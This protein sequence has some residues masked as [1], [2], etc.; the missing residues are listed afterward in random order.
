MTF[1]KIRE[2]NY[3]EMKMNVLVFEHIKTGAIH[4]HTEY[5]TVQNSFNVTFK[6]LPENNN[7]LPHILEHSVLNGSEKFPMHGVFFAMQ[8]RNFETFSNAMTG[9]DMTQ[10]PFS[11]I[12]ENGYFNLLSVYLDAVFFPKLEKEVFLQEGWRY[13]FENPQDIN[14]SLK[15]SGVVYNE[16]K[17]AYENASRVAYVEMLRQ[18][19]A[20]TQYENFSGGNP[21]EIPNLTYEEFIDFHKKFYNPSNAVFYTFGSIPVE[22]I[23]EQFES[24]VLNRFEKVVVNNKINIDKLNIAGQSYK[25]THPGENGY[26]FF[27]GYEIQD[28]DSI[29][30]MYEI[31]LML[32]LLK[33]GKNNYADMF[34]QNDIGVSAE[35]LGTLSIAKSIIY[36]S[37]KMDN[38]SSVDINNLLTDYFKNLLENGIEDQELDNI[39]D[40]LELQIREGEASTSNLGMSVIS[41]YIE[42][43]KLGIDNPEDVNNLTLLNELKKKFKNKGYFNNLIKMCFVNNTKNFEFVSQA[44]RDFGKNLE[45]KAKETLKLQEIALSET[46]KMDIVKQNILL[47]EVRLKDKDLNILPKLTLND[48]TIKYPKNIAHKEIQVGSSK[49]YS[50]TENTRGVSYVKLYYPLQNKTEEELFLQMLVLDIIDN[51]NVENMTLEQTSLWKQSKINDL[52]IDLSL[53]PQSVSEFKSF[54]VINSKSLAENT[55]ILIDKMFKYSKCISFKNRSLVVNSIENIWREFLTS[56]KDN[57]NAFAIDEAKSGFSTHIAFNKKMK[58]DYNLV[59]LK[60]VVEQLKNNKHEII[61]LL[62]KTYKDM[63]SV[64]PL[65]FF[66]G[67]KEDEGKLLK[68]LEKN[69]ENLL[70]NV[71]PAFIYKSPLIDKRTVLDFNIQVNHLAYVLPVATAEEIDGGKLMVLASYIKSYLITNIREKG[72]AYGANAIYSPDGMFTLYSYRDPN[73]LQTI[74]IFDQLGDFILNGVIDEDELNISKLN[75]IKGFNKPK[76]QVNK[77]TYEFNKILTETTIDE[78]LLIDSVLSTTSEDIKMLAKKYLINKSASIAIATNEDVISEFFSDW[79]KQVLTEKNIEVIFKNKNK[80]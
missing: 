63:F 27:K 65:I 54:F 37:F 29:E 40:T 44:D 6:T 13:V 20:N 52:G 61:D 67:D 23:H 11:T 4:Y 36:F 48:I 41:Q 70:T 75:I 51:L 5:N 62:E 17:G 57:A 45:L 16:M 69:K 38:E 24:L 10:Y 71:K 42:A 7:G 34:L 26:I 49:V 79:N 21:L 77:A 28:I 68:K 25:G 76:E 55:E 30:K 60:N 58:V 59:F 39:F 66:F 33:S 2:T 46:Q 3:P 18:A 9:F 53:I 72:G 22:K 14:S 35:G 19:C 15:Y 73:T 8:G 74:K 12:D 50:F 32:S 1:K 80:L 43:V 47:E 78:R 31:K 56:Y 64:A